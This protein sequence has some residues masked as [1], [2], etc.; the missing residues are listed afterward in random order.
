MLGH[1]F[2]SRILDRGYDY[3]L[4]SRVQNVIKVDNGYVASVDGTQE[5]EVFIEVNDQ[6][7]VK[8]MT[9]T[10]PYAQE[11]KYCKHEAAVLIEI[12]GE[13]EVLGDYY[14]GTEEDEYDDEWDEEEEEYTDYY[15]YQ[16]QYQDHKLLS[17]IEKKDKSDILKILELAI[18]DQ[19]VY[20]TIEVILK[21]KEAYENAYDVINQELSYFSKTRNLKW[22]IQTIDALNIYNNPNEDIKVVTYAIKK[23]LDNIET[24]NNEQHH[25]VFELLQKLENSYIQY[26]NQS[27]VYNLIADFCISYNNPIIYDMILY[28]YHKNYSFHFMLDRLENEIKWNYKNKELIQKYFFIV[29]NCC[30]VLFDKTVRKYYENIQFKYLLIDYYIEHKMYKK[31]VLVCLDGIKQNDDFEFYLKLIKIDKITHQTEQLKKVYKKILYHKKIGKIEYYLQL[32]SLYKKE[33][34]KEEKL[35]IINKLEKLNRNIID[36][37]LEEQM[38]DKLMNYFI[39]NNDLITIKRYENILFKHTPQQ[40]YILYQD[41]IYNSLKQTKTRDGYREVTYYLK[42]IAKHDREKAVKIYNDLITIY[43]NR[44]AMINELSKF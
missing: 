10:C 34:W 4:N 18:E 5:Y 33:E 19:H 28:L 22:I 38:Y 17:R 30:P 24:M 35:K 42:A 44:P 6:N 8:S 29:T 32:K 25:F 27:D 26:N 7:K 36:I 16:T 12:Y 23:A 37:Y 14:F 13:Q 3:Y 11:G 31:A 9:C 41:Y 43:S 40:I 21:Q 20:R 15:S 2:A 39:K 1:F